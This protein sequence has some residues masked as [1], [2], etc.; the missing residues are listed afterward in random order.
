MSLSDHRRTPGISITKYTRARITRSDTPCAIEVTPTRNVTEDDVPPFLQCCPRHG[1]STTEISWIL[2]SGP[3]PATMI[4]KYQF[5]YRQHVQYGTQ[6]IFAVSDPDYLSPSCGSA[7]SCNLGGTRSPTARY[8]PAIRAPLLEY[9]D[10]GYLL[11]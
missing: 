3:Y 5:G 2:S 7:C 1:M 6:A 8:I 4:R 10:Q 11:M 9:M